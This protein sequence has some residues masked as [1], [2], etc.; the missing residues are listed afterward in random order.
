M[1]ISTYCCPIH[2]M[3][4]PAQIRISICSSILTKWVRWG[5]SFLV[6]QSSSN[7]KILRCHCMAWGVECV[8]KGNG[9]YHPGTWHSNVSRMYIKFCLALPIQT[10]VQ[11]WQCY[12]LTMQMNK[13]LSLAH[14]DEYAFAKLIRS[15]PALPIQTPRGITFFK[16]PNVGHVASNCPNKTFPPY[17]FRLQ[18]LSSSPGAE[19]HSS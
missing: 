16:C 4:Q 11:I 14:I 19:P 17:S 15:P 18:H 8:C 5:F 1:W 12:C 10:L 13:S 7:P 9:F 3:I 2:C 6:L